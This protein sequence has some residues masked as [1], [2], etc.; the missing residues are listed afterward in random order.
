M[1]A[2]KT[3]NHQNLLCEIADVWKLPYQAL[4]NFNSWFHFLIEI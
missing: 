3:G 4:T 1:T 2:L